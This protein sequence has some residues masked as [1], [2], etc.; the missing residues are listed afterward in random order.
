MKNNK[1]LPMLFAMLLV[2]LASCNHEHVWNEGKITKEPTEYE[3]GIKEFEC[4]KC[5]EVSYQEI[6]KLPHSH[7]YSEEWSYDISSH[8]HNANCGHSSEITDKADHAWN[9]G[10]VVKAPTY[11][12]QGI[13]TYT[14][15][16]CGAT[17]NEKIDVVAHEHYY[18]VPGQTL[19][20]YT[21][22]TNHWY[23]CDLCYMPMEVQAHSGGTATCTDKAVCEVCNQPYGE[24]K[25]HNVD[26]TV[27]DSNE[28]GHWNI[29]SNGN[30]G[31]HTTLV[32][33]NYNKKVAESAY[34]A[35]NATCEVGKLYYYSCEC[36]QKGSET[37]ES[38][39]PLGH[40]GG[41]ATCT[42]LA[43]CSRC[44]QPYGE[45]AEHEYTDLTPRV[46]ATC[47]SN[48]K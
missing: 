15:N 18:Q 37:F 4:E 2:S 12:D 8:W 7:T 33:H 10:E 28:A 27:F 25:P 16:V 26:G 24:L 17:K 46:E 35:A 1:S 40:I 11:K 9:E 41:S 44:L 48:G 3:T 42:T 5:D 13:K 47:T 36:G 31:E 29:C 32:G 38:G 21:D 34:F 45:Y 43:N 23:V 30:C 20:Y 39:D 19:Q 14:C 6:E 22:A